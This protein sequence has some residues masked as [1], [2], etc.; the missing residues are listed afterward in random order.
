[1]LVRRLALAFGQARE[2]D[3]KMHVGLINA[4]SARGLQ[5]GLL[6]QRAGQVFQGPLHLRVFHRAGNRP[7]AHR[8]KLEGLTSRWITP[9]LCAWSRASATP[10]IIRATVSK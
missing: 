10:V 5:V 9:C 2:T 3:E 4:R 6:R 7:S 1:M 8:S